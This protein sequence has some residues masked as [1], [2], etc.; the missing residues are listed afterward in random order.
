M[1]VTVD[2]LIRRHNNPVP[3][4][5]DQNHCYR[6]GD[7]VTWKVQPH[8]GWGMKED[9]DKGATNFFLITV[10][11]VPVNE[12]TLRL[13]D[14][15]DHEMDESDPENPIWL[16]LRK[17]HVDP[18]DMPPGIRQILIDTGKLTVTWT[19]VVNFVRQYT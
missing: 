7:I 12:L 17:F 3:D 6:L 14:W 8:P 11:D 19:Q 10:T 4:G 13:K 16:K 9:P 2:L 1:A 18:N 5:T 15:I